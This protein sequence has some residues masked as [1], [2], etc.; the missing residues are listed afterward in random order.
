[1]YTITIIVSVMVYITIIYI[2]LNKWEII[3]NIFEYIYITH[4]IWIQ[5]NMH[6]YNIKCNN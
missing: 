4:L 2:I 5:F 1:M 6:I 3:I